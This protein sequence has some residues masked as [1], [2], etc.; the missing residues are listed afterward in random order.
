MRAELEA[1]QRNAQQQLTRLQEVAS[2]ST[3]HNT[4]TALSYVA[5]LL[6]CVAWQ[7]FG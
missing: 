5:E 7:R 2:A 1:A 4:L 3:Q 6:C